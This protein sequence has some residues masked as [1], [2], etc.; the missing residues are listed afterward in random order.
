MAFGSS[1]PLRRP[2]RRFSPLPGATGLTVA[3]VAARRHDT[4]SRATPAR[5][6]PT[7]QYDGGLS[8]AVIPRCCPSLVCALPQTARATPVKLSYPEPPKPQIVDLTDR[9]SP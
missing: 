4:I 6:V 5:R 3:P 9:S 1:T 8:P 2:S 7:I